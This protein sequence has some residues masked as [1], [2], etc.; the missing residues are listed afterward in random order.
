MPG[1]GRTLQSDNPTI[2]TAFH[3]AL[4]HQLFVVLIIG[5]V[6]G[7]T[8]NVIRSVQY[9]RL[10]AAGRATFP[11]GP[12][13]NHSEPPARRILRI[14]LGAMWIFDGLLQLQTS[15]PLGLPT[16]VI[17]PSASTSPAWVQHVVNSGLNIWS[18][19][20]VQAAA[21]TVWIQVGLGLW[22]L[23]APRGLWSR[24]GG[25]ASVGWGL[26]VWVFGEAFGGIFAPGVSWLFGA[27]G[28]VLLYCVGG[29]LV[30]LP[31]RAYATPRLGRL[32]LTFTGV[33]FIGMAVL[34]AW[35]GRGF[36]QGRLH[37]TAHVGTLASMV[38]QMAQTSQPHF[39]AAWLSSFGDF[40]TAHGWAVNLGVVIV[41]LAIG[42]ALCSGRRRLVLPA[43]IC[44]VALC[45]AD[46]VLVEDTGFLGGTGTDV[47]NMLPSALILVAGY[48]A[49]VRLPAP[50]GEADAVDEVVHQ[51][52]PG[53][54][55]WEWVTPVYLIR[56][57]AAL[58]AVAIVLVGT[59]PMT[60]AAANPNADP[61]ISEATNGTPN[62]IDSPAP[63]FSLIDQHGNPVSLSSLRGHTVALTF[64][65]PVCT[66]DCPL[67]AQE[68][69]QA[70]ERLGTRKC[71]RLLRC[72]RRQSHLSVRRLHR[73]LRPPR[74]LGPRRQLALPDRIGGAAAPGLELLRRPGG[75]RRGRGDDRPQRP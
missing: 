16:T 66:S 67:I 12:R 55:W 24:F 60:L 50:I 41:M 7:I 56:L 72:D 52:T 51:A 26:I 33:F 59:A 63:P 19:H 61:I 13:W 3:S 15:M 2:V 70:D 68:F 75:D 22:L 38:A 74:R 73:G 48:V 45:L 14:G 44:A 43:V 5:A 9:R 53:G 1:M 23:V 31:D 62:V 20:P 58:G 32:V 64:L 37:S 39:L 27:P 21:A 65:D 35:P 46:W 69:H 36:W 4:L 11:T 49:M 25:L 47:N 40:D 71:K 17:K 54:R 30:A 10:A 8:F 28:A 42:V 34:Q 29:F 18:L 6:L 57:V